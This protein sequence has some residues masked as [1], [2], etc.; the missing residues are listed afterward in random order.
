MI[1]AIQTIACVI[2]GAV[3]GEAYY[4]WKWRRK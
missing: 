3:V 2:L 1:D 4:K